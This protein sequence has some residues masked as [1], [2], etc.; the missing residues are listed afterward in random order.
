MIRIFKLKLF[1]KGLFKKSRKEVQQ[2]AENS[3]QFLNRLMMM[4]KPFR[5]VQEEV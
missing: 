3:R 1:K 2:T 5:G 4:D